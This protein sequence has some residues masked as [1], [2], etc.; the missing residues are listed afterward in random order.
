MKK[1]IDLGLLV[2][3]VA[4]A[5][6]MLFHGIAKLSN[7]E[8][9]KHM[10]TE[11]GIP[12][13]LAYGVFITELMAPILIIIGFRTRLASIVFFLGMIT[14]MLLAHSEH[15]LAVSETGGLQVELLLLYALGALVI[16]FTGPGKFA[17]STTKTWD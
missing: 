11:V 14:A 10:L 7:L 2:L 8:G 13:V 5:G 1:N 9:I 16:F 3:R 4:I 15:I 6:L 17:M 12:S